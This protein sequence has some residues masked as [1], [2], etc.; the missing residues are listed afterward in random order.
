MSPKVRSFVQGAARHVSAHLLFAAVLL[1]AVAVRVIAARGYPALLWAGDSYG[2]LDSAVKFRPH[3]GRPSGYGIFLWTLKPFH[4]VGIVVG[5]QAALGVAAG[6]M[7]YALVWRHARAAWPRWIWLPGLPA[8]AAAVPVLYDGNL[9]QS[10]HMM[11]ADSL[12]TFLVVAV[13]TVVLWNPRLT[14]WTGPLA[15]TLTAF[16]ALTR[17]AGLPLLILVVL[18][19]LLRWSGWRRT[20]GA[21]ALAG[22]TFAVPFLAY[23]NWFDDHHGSFAV[24]KGSNVWMYGRVMA[25]A[26]CAKIKPPPDLAVMCPKPDGD[27]RISPTF[28]SMWTSDSPFNQIPGGIYGHQGNEMAG[29]FSD[30]AV[31]RQFGDYLD[32]VVRDTRRAFDTGREPYPTPWTEENLRF[33]RGEQWSDEQWLL[34]SQY[35]G[36]TA[37]PRVIEPHASWI[38]DYQERFHTAGPALA[39]L[40]AVGLVGILI[41]LR[42]RSRWGGSILLPWST[43]SAMLVIPAATAD[44]DYRY[45]APAVPLSCLAAVLTFIPN[46]R[47]APEEP[48]AEPAVIEEPHSVST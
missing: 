4:D 31:E 2:Y 48:A 8:T 43:A 35:G 10:E 39:A 42:P 28:R 46:R 22:V 11:L 32:V 25:F 9:I 14:W 7:V 24:T 6:T 44:F 33:P 36:D 37:R 26:D 45:L 5:A 41:R 23:M 16:A 21:V 38:R 29:R 20:L 27:P 34:A 19:M 13:V 1:G 12:F 47:K 18:A 15:G 3:I 17:L 40:L 30:L